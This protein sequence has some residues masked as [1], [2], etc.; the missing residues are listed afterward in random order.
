MSDLDERV[1]NISDG[2]EDDLFGDDAGDDASQIEDNPPLPSDDDLASDHDRA[3]S[4]TRDY[5]DDRSEAE[6][7]PEPEPINREKKVVEELLQRHG[8]PKTKD[9]NVSRFAVA[10]ATVSKLLADAT[11]QG[12]EFSAFYSRNARPRR[13][14]SNC[15]GC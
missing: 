2:A 11:S 10:S 4:V 8:L 7:S 13:F 14:C 6:A 15:M 5:R 9:G 12:A 1:D 3:R